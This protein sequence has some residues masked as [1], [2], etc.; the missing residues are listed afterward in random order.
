MTNSGKRQKL[1]AILTEHKYNNIY[2]GKQHNRR[3][4]RTNFT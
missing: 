3:P 2:D 1:T 4:A